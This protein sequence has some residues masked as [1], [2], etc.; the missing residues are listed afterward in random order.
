[1]R[2]AVGLA[3]IMIITG[4]LERMP[5]PSTEGQALDFTAG[6]TTYLPLSPSWGSEYGIVTPVEVSISHARHVFIADTSLN[7]VLVF[8]QAGSR[9]DDTDS[10]FATL[11]FSHIADDFN[12]IDIA[13]DGRLNL[14]VIN[15]SYK[16]YRWNQYWNMHG[17]DSVA[18]EI[19]FKNTETGEYRW[20]SVDDDWILLYLNTPPWTAL[21]DSS[22]YVYNRAVADSLLRPHLFFDMTDEYNQQQDI[23][24]G[25]KAETTRF[26]AISAARLKDYFFYA[27]DSVNDRIM[28]ARSIR[29][30]AVK[31]GD[32]DAYFTH[33]SYFVDNVATTGYGA[34]TVN[35][36]VGLDVDNFGNV[37]YSQFGKQMYVHSV[38]PS[39]DF[40]TNFELHYDDIMSPE[41]YL[42]PYDVAVDSRQMIYVANT[43]LREI[44]V[45]KG[46]GSFFKKAGI[47]KERV[48][49]TWW[50]PF[51]TEKIQLDT[52]LWINDSTSIDTTIWLPG[53]LDSAL[54]DTF[55]YKEI[56]GQLVRPVSV[57]VDERG[58]IYVCDPGQGSVRRFILSTSLDEDLTDID[59]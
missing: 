49:T 5:L 30:G 9:I 32:G 10:T 19:L 40:T 36:P 41:Q 1:M 55:Y 24:Y 20:F 54:V 38:S 15:G 22:K 56:K 45:F 13:I 4:C 39:D 42:N 50:A 16:V 51:E 12:P 3:L 59:Q 8:D 37:Y 57:D 33:Y 28:R 2:I 29:T 34:G 23:Y 17:I 35:M 11:D 58:V 53:S 26:S 25:L 31:L 52:T 7:A 14:L 46:D 21:L 6:D 27:A 48:D 47:E 18:S 44:L 43:D